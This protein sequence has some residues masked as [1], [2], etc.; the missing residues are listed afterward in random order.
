MKQHP[1]R[2]KFLNELPYIAAGAFLIRD[3]TEEVTLQSNMNGSLSTMTF[4]K[5]TRLVVDMIGYRTFDSGFASSSFSALLDTPPLFQ[6]I[7]Q[8]TSLIRTHSS[9]GAGTANTSNMN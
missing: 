6:T 1:A 7:T 2:S 8:N 4:P 9:L 5:G 3:T